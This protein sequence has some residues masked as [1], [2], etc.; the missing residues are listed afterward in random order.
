MRKK[1]LSCI[2]S[3]ETTTQAMAMENACK[4]KQI[5]GRIIPLPKEISAGCGLAW[6][7]PV[8]EKER[9]QTFMASEQLVY[10]QCDEILF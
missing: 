7:A 6:W 4:K 5:P 3:F 10:E 9:I 2:F 1:E 8:K